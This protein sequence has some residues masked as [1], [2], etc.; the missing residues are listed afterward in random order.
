MAGNVLRR[1]APVEPG[2]RKGRMLVVS[3]VLALGFAALL[4][5]A[6]H[7]QVH[8]HDDFVR[9]SAGQHQ[10]TITLRA[11]RGAIYDRN[12][13]ELALTAMV[14]SIFGV[15]QDVERPR[16]AAAKLA[17]VLRMD[18]AALM[19]RLDRPGEFIWL[20]RHV[21]PA[22]A[23]AV[24][25]LG[26]AGIHLR[27]E[28]RRFYPN[29]SL[30]GPLIGFAG[31]D[32]NGLEGVERD[33]EHYLQG[34]EYVLEGLR[35]AV[36]RKAMPG[37]SVPPE[38][39]VG[40]ALTLTIDA[41]IQQITEAALNHQVREMEARDG[42]VVVMDPH[43]GDIL[44]LAQTPVFD[45]NHFRSAEPAAWRNRAITDV[46]EPG[47]TI[48]PLLVAAA[49]DLGKVTPDQVWDGYYGKMRVGS[50]VI[51]D[52]HGEKEMTTLEIVQKSSNVGAVQV[53]QRIGK[54]SWYAYLRAYGFGEPSG[55]GLRG[56]QIGS[57]RPAS[58]WGQIHLATFSYGYGLSVTP[59]QMARAV[60]TIANGGKLMRPRLVS[61]V[62]D[63]RG[64]VV[65]R[66][67]VREQRRV[68][69][70]KAARDITRGMVM[71]TEKGG[72]GRRA[73]VPGYVVAG[74]TGTAHKV[75]PVV[76]GYSKDK[77]RSSFVGFVPAEAPRLVVFISI[78][79]PQKAQY[80]GVVAAPIFSA[81]ARE[82][83]PYLGVEASEGY[84]GGDAEEE[85]VA[86]AAEGIDPQARPWWFEESVLT[87]AASHLVV[88]D[89]RGQPLAAVLEKAAELELALRVEGAGLVVAQHPQAGSLLPRDAV[90]AVTLDLPGK[91]PV[92]AEGVPR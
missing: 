88:P 14:P 4:V 63:A 8:Q 56:E 86:D 13:R 24:E 39:L 79:E 36:G 87:G 84:V 29:R 31:I 48:K 3:V 41:R 50:K 19:D 53:A 77:V 44:A 35:D 30:A 1:R 20:K 91:P 57:L 78:D 42:V 17:E 74:K 62:T 27:D 2:P 43:T 70:E 67:P 26:I 65:E 7:L 55:L 90:V 54:D 72:T 11:S 52:V 10:T 81:I 76:R 61:H 71:V 73:R 16:E 6:W 22:E 9:R 23:R 5:R 80:G 45:P 64:Q 18:A 82:A 21:S 40:H 60:A 66:F 83:L 75:D 32:G 33:F 28:P 37:G 46:L 59:I 58:E 92:A 89:L 69:S 47:S 51:S 38:H 15:P 85:D 49:L 34:R 12:G 25:A 68:M